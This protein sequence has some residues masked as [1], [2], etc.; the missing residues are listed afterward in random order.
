MI[1]NVRKSATLYNKNPAAHWLARQLSKQMG[2]TLTEA[3]IR[4]LEH[5]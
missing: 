5:Q 1:V 3:V 4:A 2:V